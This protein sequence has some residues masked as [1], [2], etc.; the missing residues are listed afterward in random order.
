MKEVSLY[1]F[2][3]YELPPRVC[4]Q[5]RYTLTKTRFRCACPLCSASLSQKNS[6]WIHS[7]SHCGSVHGTK[8]RNVN[9]TRLAHVIHTCTVSVC[10]KYGANLFYQIRFALVHVCQFQIL[11]TAMNAVCIES[12]QSSMHAVRVWHQN[13]SQIV[14][15]C[16]HRLSLGFSSKTGY[17]F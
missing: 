5:T 11:Y 8:T 16:Y 4:Y 12:K 7:S 2:T 13:K 17:K 14:P 3:K 6:L 10:V 1:I 9:C 15:V